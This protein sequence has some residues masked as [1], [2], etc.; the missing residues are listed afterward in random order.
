MKSPILTLTLQQRNPTASL[1]TQGREDEEGRKGTEREIE[2]EGGVEARGYCVSDKT[3][4]AA[5]MK[6]LSWRL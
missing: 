1:S 4:Q 3:P 5:L 2:G 6:S